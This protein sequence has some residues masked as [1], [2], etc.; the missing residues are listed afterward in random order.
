MNLTFLGD[1]L[2]H[3]KGAVLDVVNKGGV[4][5]QLRV[6]PMLSDQENWTKADVEVY[7]RLLHVFDDQVLAH[8]ASL[9]NDRKRYF[10]EVPTGCDLF[11]D[12]DTGIATTYKRPNERVRYLLLPEL[13]ALLDSSGHLRAH[14]ERLVAVYQHRPTG[15]S[16]SKRAESIINAVLH[17]LPN[18]TSLSY[19][20]SQVAMLFFSGASSRLEEA[21]GIFDLVL[22]RHASAR[23]RI[24]RAHRGTA[25]E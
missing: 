15:G 14:A 13:V 21:K 7:A 10:S 24:W 3:W 4:W 1:A 19:E 16:M 9:A 11:L 20:C 25:K 23:I 5:A 12:P 8:K 6:E 2:D 18:I 17:A 22:G